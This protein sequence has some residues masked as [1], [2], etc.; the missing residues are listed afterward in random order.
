MTINRL[1]GWAEVYVRTKG[2]D[3]S[4]AYAH[5]Q[6]PPDLHLAAQRYGEVHRESGLAL[7]TV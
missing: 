7:S 6:F 3:N 5:Y 2:R 4:I 1:Y